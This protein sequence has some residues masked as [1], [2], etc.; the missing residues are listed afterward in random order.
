MVIFEVKKRQV[1]FYGAILIWSSLV[2]DFWWG[3]LTTDYLPWWTFAQRAMA[4]L[5]HLHW[6]VLESLMWLGA[7]IVVFWL[8]LCESKW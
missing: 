6:H 2:A 7:I 4:I 1:V 3:Y 5:P 8:Y